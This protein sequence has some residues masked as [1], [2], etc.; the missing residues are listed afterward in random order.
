MRYTFRVVV[1]FFLMLPIIAMGKKKRTYSTKDIVTNS[2]SLLHKQIGDSL[3]SY[4]KLDSGSYYT[5]KKGSKRRFD[6]FAEEK[7]LSKGFEK[8]YM[9]YAYVMPYPE[10]PDYDTISGIISFTVQKDDT[11]FSI[12]SQPDM[13]FIPA[14]AIAHEGCKFISKEDALRIAMQDNLKRGVNPPYAILKY[15]PASKQFSWVVLSLIWD[16]KNFEDEKK[17]KKDLVLIEA[18]SG[19]ILKHTTIFYEQEVN[20]IIGL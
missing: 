5:Y 2:D 1:F 8:A 7:K 20:D 13:S 9:R 15:I 10:C 14:T 16:E 4:C 6:N 18:T 19:Q 12:E 17:T 3:F 11:V